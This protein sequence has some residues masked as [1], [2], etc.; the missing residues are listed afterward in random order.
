MKT[1]ITITPSCTATS[2]EMPVAAKGKQSMKDSA[3][4]IAKTEGASQ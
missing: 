3:S 2:Y 4:Y 1:I